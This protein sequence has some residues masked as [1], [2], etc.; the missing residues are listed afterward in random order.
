MHYAVLVT[1]AT[2]VNAAKA[3]V[4]RAVKAHDQAAERTAR[5]ELAIAVL[6]VQLARW[7]ERGVELTGEQRAEVD[8]ILARL[9]RTPDESERSNDHAHDDHS[10]LWHF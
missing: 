8:A 6:R 2:T 1:D 5:S 4:A 10:A 7:V 9:D 3:A